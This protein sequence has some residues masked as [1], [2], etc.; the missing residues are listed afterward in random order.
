MCRRHVLGKELFHGVS[1]YSLN[2]IL[3]LIILLLLL[4]FLSCRQLRRYGRKAHFG[5]LTSRRDDDMMIVMDVLLLLELWHVHVNDDEILA[6]PLQ[7]LP[8][9]NRQQGQ[10]G[11]DKTATE[12]HPETLVSS[13]YERVR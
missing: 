8:K 13:S 6:Q 3:L 5:K 1:S 4:L 10:Q 11:Q 9:P 7:L 2:G 12:P